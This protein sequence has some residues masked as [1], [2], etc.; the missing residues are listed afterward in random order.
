MA[1]YK[2]T[3]VLVKIGDGQWSRVTLDVMQMDRMSLLEALAESRTFAVE[4]RDVALSKCVVKVCVSASM[5]E[6]SNEDEVRPGAGEL[7]GAKTLRDLVN[8]MDTAALPY[9]Y[10]HVTLPAIGELKT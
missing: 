7:K 2:P 3:A 1:A 10:I 4:L 6:P 5:E 9:L 8:G